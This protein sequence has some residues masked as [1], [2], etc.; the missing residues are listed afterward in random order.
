MEDIIAAQLLGNSTIG[1]TVDL[2][3]G[4]GLCH[5]LQK[6]LKDSCRSDNSNLVEFA[7]NNGWDFETSR[8]SF[9]TLTEN[10]FD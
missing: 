1:R 4:G 9:N 2:M 6:D 5:F 10:S 8:S 7:L 3:F